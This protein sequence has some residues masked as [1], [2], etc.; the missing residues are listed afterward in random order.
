M[1][2]GCGMEVG[3]DGGRVCDR[4]FV[5]WYIPPQLNQIFWEVRFLSRISELFLINLILNLRKVSNKTIHK[6]EKSG[7]L[8]TR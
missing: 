6:S 2:V 7:K 1:E 4:S 3:S 5:C 8:S